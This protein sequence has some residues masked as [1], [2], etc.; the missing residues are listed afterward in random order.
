MNIVAASYKTAKN[1]LVNIDRLLVAHT[2]DVK[3]TAKKKRQLWACV[4]VL[5]LVQTDR[6]CRRQTPG[7]T[8]AVETLGLYNVSVV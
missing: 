2:T 7:D 5:V 8:T 4:V 1:S 6:R 3:P